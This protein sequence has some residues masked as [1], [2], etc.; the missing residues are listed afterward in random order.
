M[1]D[2]YQLQFQS[3]YLNRA[4]NRLQI[5]NPDQPSSTFQSTGI[6]IEEIM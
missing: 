3:Y 1:R 6:A 4:G 5:C 2:F